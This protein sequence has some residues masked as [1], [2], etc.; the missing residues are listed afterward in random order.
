MSYLVDVTIIGPHDHNGSLK[1]HLAAFEYTPR[2]SLVMTTA[3]H[4]ASDLKDTTGDK[5]HTTPVWAGS[6]N[7]LDEHAFLEHLAAFDWGITAER[8]VVVIHAEDWTTI[9]TPE[10]WDAP[11]TMYDARGQTQHLVG[12]LGAMRPPLSAEE[13][14]A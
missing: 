3:M 8:T 1:R 12:L 6:F 9:W 4:P 10:G 2:G 11:A 7:F 14:D 5:V 13:Q